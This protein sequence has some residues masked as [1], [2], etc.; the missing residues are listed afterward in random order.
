MSM[1]TAEFLAVDEQVPAKVG[2]DRWDRPEI[3]PP[4]GGDTIPYT[5]ASTLGKALDDEAGLTAWRKRMILIG[6]YELLIEHPSES[7]TLAVAAHRN[8][9]DPTEMNKL[10]DRADVAADS[11]AA[12]T[13]G[14]ALHRVMDLIDEGEDPYVPD[15]YRT[16][17]AEYVQATRGLR[18][19]RKETFVVDDELQCAGSYD[20]LWELK[21]HATAPDGTV[22][23][24]GTQL[25]GD[26]KTG[27]DIK[28]GHC[29][30]G[31]QLSVYAHGLRYDPETDARLDP[32]PISQDW[33]LVVHAP[34]KGMW[35]QKG[36]LRY[37]VKLY[38]IDLR[39]GREL[40]KLA[41]TVRAARK[42]KTMRPA[43][44]VPTWVDQVALTDRL[45]VLRALWGSC[46]E[47]Q[48]LTP[49]VEAAFLARSKELAS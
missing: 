1:T 44:I 25:I 26:L 42:T 46:V 37:W 36:V 35:T 5:R 41:H 34:I 10:T 17:I 23:P 20:R 30:W 13:S 14:T 19:V 40:A 15:Q 49:E 48:A 33:G 9:R 7:F 28:Y 6:A 2:R 21:F 8:D 18:M 38:W 39:K 29:S 43:E 47:E 16:N 4:Q 32:E 45:E 24:P 12:A 22:L 27:K 3:V 11:D 31:V